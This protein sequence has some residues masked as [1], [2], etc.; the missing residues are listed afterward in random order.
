MGQRGPISDQERAGNLANLGLQ[1]VFE[2]FGKWG[3]IPRKLASL[4]RGSGRYNIANLALVCTMGGGAAIL[5]SC[6][7][8]PLG[9]LGPL[10][11]LVPL[12]PPGTISLREIMQVVQVV[13]VPQAIEVVHDCKIAK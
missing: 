7:L 13:Q 4:G 12:G 6:T 1:F 10:V 11:P 8:A 5:K 9:P 2:I 3:K